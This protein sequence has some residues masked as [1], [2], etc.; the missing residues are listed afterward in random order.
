M[1]HR[2]KDP[3][4]EEYAVA[5]QM[6]QLSSSDIAEISRNSVLQS[7]FEY[8]FK[9]HWIGPEY[10]IPGPEGN[11]IT[12]TNLPNIRLQYRMEVL[13]EELKILHAG[14]DAQDTVLGFNSVTGKKGRG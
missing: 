3:L 6:Y 14:K 9:A 11:E 1:L 10:A 5:A 8:P 4:V 13:H 2:T 12:L 7:G